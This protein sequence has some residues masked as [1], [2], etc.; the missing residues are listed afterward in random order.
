M[1][2]SSSSN[3]IKHNL[4]SN[5][6]SMRISPEENQNANAPHHVQTQQEMGAS[7][8]FLP[9]ADAIVS[10]TSP[11]HIGSLSYSNNESLGA[12]GAASTNLA[13][14]QRTLNILAASLESKSGFRNIQ[15]SSN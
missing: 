15:S 7:S 3:N 14:A 10:D 11:L 5:I 4:S 12:A 6:V 8:Q 13:E 9:Y 1:Q 2:K